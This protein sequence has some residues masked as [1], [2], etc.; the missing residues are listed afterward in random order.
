MDPVEAS[1]QKGRRGLGMA[2]SDFELEADLA[3]REE[4]V[5][6]KWSALYTMF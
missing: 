2:P 5:R 3:W 6:T 4:E 1:K